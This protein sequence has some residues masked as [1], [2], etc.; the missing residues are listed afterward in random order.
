MYGSSTVTKQGL[1]KFEHDFLN[2]ISIPCSDWLCV[3]I[4]TIRGCD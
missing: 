1:V 4:K 3:Y 2:M